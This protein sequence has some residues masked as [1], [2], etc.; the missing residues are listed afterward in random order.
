MNK[1]EKIQEHFTKIMKLLGLDL[2]E[3][4]LKGTPHRLAKL[5]VDEIFSGLDSANF[6]KI[7]TIE[8]KFAIDEMI[9]VEDIIVNSTCEHHFLP[10][11]G[12]AKISYIPKDKIIGLSK[13][14]RLVEY[15]SK[16]PQVQERLTKDIMEQL[17]LSLETSDIAVSIKATHTCVKTRG[18]KDGLSFTKTTMLS[19]SFKN[20]SKTRNEF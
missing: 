10:F 5:Y 16:R 9:T 17:K 7:M 18:I 4:S 3:D 8:N 15:Y 2:T 19:G 13:I 12:T 1:K 11:F 6:P 20:D 14:N